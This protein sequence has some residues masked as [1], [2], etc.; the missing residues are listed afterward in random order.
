[1]LVG[2]NRGLPCLPFTKQD[3]FSR[4]MGFSKTKIPD[5]LLRVRFCSSGSNFI[6][7]N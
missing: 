1:M 6:F 2:Q 3:D 5:S 4:Y 7:N